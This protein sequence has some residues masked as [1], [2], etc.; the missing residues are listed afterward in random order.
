MRELSMDEVNNVAGG[1]FGDWLAGLELAKEVAESAYNLL[2]GAYNANSA[3][4]GEDFANELLAA[5][6]LGA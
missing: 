6:G 1:G 2:E 4:Y 3:V 5:G